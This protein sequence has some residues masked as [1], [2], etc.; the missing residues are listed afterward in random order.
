ML[1]TGF[2]AWKCLSLTTVGWDLLFF[3]GSWWGMVSA[4]VL[5]DTV[6]KYMLLRHAAYSDKLDDGYDERLLQSVDFTFE[7]NQALSI[8][9]NNDHK[10]YI[11]TRL[12]VGYSP[13]N[14][15][16]SSSLSPM[17]SRRRS[18]RQS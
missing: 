12:L 8:F 15:T 11:Y 6:D 7:S 4:V 3:F 13:R 9:A 16:L 2:W 10:T 1:F 5:Y 17:T 18:A 14:N